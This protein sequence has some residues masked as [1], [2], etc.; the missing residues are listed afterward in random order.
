M[1][2]FVSK[3]IEMEIVY[4]YYFNLFLSAPTHYDIYRD[5]LTFSTRETI[6]FK[7]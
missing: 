7:N 4:N 3:F 1:Q 6:K 5:V 2:N